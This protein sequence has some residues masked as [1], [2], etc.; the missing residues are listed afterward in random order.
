MNAAE[1]AEAVRRLAEGMALVGLTVS[2][3][4]N[5]GGSIVGYAPVHPAQLLAE[6]QKRLWVIGLDEDRGARIVGTIGGADAD[7]D[8]EYLAEHAEAGARRLEDP[9]TRG[10]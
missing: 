5:P 8:G 6:W 4:Q 2:T 9:N 7:L 1:Q 10:R 3:P